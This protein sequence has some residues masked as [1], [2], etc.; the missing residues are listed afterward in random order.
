VN[1]LKR[2][3]PA[4]RRPKKARVLLIPDQW[5]GSVQE[6]YHF[7][8]GYLAPVMLWIDRN[9]GKPLA[10]RDCGPMNPWLDLLLHSSDLQIMT[11]GDMLRLFSGKYHQAAVLV[12]MDDP[13]TFNSK[14]LA[15]FRQLVFNAVNPAPAT[16]DLAITVVD[17]ITSGTFNLTPAAEVP[18]SGAE[19]RSTPNL[20]SVMS[21]Y[22]TVR[23][24]RII[25]AAEISVNEQLTIFSQTSI[26]VA[27]HGAGLTNMIWMPRGGRI[28]EILPPLPDYVSPI[29]ANLAAA[30][31]HTH[32]VVRQESEHAPVDA[33]LLLQAVTLAEHS[34]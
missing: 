12:G 6:Y 24:L 34:P 27:Q 4:K 8:L 10:M 3:L 16:E 32:Q 1:S 5:S 2:L 13:K 33:S 15:R 30:C 23:S 29:F 25:D 9:P 7:I 17:R 14:D 18:A 22:R 26:L 19:V 11:P 20:S 31:G 21:G 28:V